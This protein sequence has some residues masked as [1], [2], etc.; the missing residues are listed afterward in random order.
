MN[1]AGEISLFDAEGAITPK[2][3]RQIGPQKDETLES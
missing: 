2:T 3:L 1:F